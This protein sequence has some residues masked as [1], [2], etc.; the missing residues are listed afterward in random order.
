MMSLLPCHTQR[1]V[2]GV[3]R[4]RWAGSHAPSF[5]YRCQRLSGCSLGIFL[6]LGFT[7]FRTVSVCADPPKTASA[8]AQEAFRTVGTPE[9][10]LALAGEGY[11]IKK[12]QHFIIAYNGKYEHVLRLVGRVEGVYRAILRFRAG[13]GASDSPPPTGLPILFFDSFEDYRDFARTLGENVEALAGF[14]HHGTNT[15]FFYNTLTRPDV[16]EFNARIEGLREQLAGLGRGSLG[17]SNALRRQMTAW[18]IQ[19]DAFVERV[20]RLVIQHE[21]AHHCLFNGQVHSRTVQNPDWLV[22]GLACQFEVPQSASYGGLGS[23]NY[24]RLKDVRNAFELEKSI[25]APTQKQR[26]V[27]FESGRFLPLTELIGDARVMSSRKDPNQ[28]DRYAQS[29]SLVLYLQRKHRQPFAIYMTSIRSRSA[30]AS[31]DKKGEVAAF[32]SAFGPLDEA[33]ED[34]WI[35]YILSFRPV[36]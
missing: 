8:S 26:R 10:L 34:D 18:R 9:A 32:E 3:S 2:V 17:Q 23:I 5:E 21:V 25:L 22:E 1:T 14:Y 4:P 28:I 31:F 27:A 11:K 24:E 29:W 15:A 19:R 36:Q 7:L 20:N 12:T 30:G 33:F 13:I 6:V 35:R 16:Q